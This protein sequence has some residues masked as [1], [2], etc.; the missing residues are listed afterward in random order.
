MAGEKFG[1]TPGHQ[2]VTTETISILSQKLKISSLGRK[3]KVD[4]HGGG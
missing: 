3:N 1:Q 2:G 4:S